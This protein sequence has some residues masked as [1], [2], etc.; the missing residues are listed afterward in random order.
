MGC[1][2]GAVNRAWVCVPAWL[3]WQ[4]AGWRRGRMT[5]LGWWSR[6]LRR[7]GRGRRCCQAQVAASTQ[8][9]LS[10]PSPRTARRA[11]LM[12]PAR[13]H[14]WRCGPARGCGLC[15]RPGPA[16]EMGDLAFDEGPVCPVALLPGGVTLDGAGF[17]QDVLVRMDGRSCGPGGRWCTQIAAG[18]RRTRAGTMPCR[19]PGQ[20]GRCRWAAR[21]GRS[22]CRVPDRRRSGPWGTGRRHCGRRALRHDR[23]PLGPPGPRG[24]PRPVR[25]VAD[26]VRLVSGAGQLIKQLPGSVPVG[27][28]AAVAA[29]SPVSSESGSADRCALYPSQ[30]R[31]RHLCPCRAAVSTVKITRSFAVLRAIR[32]TPSPPCSTSCPATRASKSAASAA[33]S[34]SCCPSSAPSADSASLT[35][36]STS[37]SRAAGSSQ[38]H[39]GFPG[40]A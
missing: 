7:L 13:A 9:V 31:L 10:W 1:F 11:Q 3:A 26:D 6:V 23:E 37:T 25:G 28:F 38:S 18:R 4:Q 33:G 30:W 24:W 40:P 32:N 35:S 14:R 2:S 36:S 21:P 19:R 5:G 20:P 29:T 22:R 16:G 27:V 15:G 39:G 34:G 17:L 8:P 12:A